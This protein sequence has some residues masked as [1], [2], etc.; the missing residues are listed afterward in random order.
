MQILF[1]T[2]KYITLLLFFA[3]S[4]NNVLSKLL[5]LFPT[6]SFL[7]TVYSTEWMYCYLTV[8][9][10]LDNWITPKARI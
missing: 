7:I 5:I 6:S 9:Q 2:Q 1:K 3:F 4:L 8:L 10:L